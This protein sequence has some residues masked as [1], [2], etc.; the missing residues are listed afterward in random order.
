ML[1]LSSV[2]LGTIA[3]F[4]G[5]AFGLA[6]SVL[7]VPALVLFKIP[8]VKGIGGM[9]M[10]KIVHHVLGKQIDDRNRGK[11]FKDVKVVKGHLVLF[12]KIPAFV[13]EK[14]IDVFY[15]WSTLRADQIRAAAGQA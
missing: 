9:S 3:G 12:G 7:L 10:N 8:L 4:I 1:Y 13:C 2:V 5:G 14:R 15:E 11:A 6:G